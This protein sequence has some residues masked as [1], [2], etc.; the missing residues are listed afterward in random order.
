MPEGL[1]ATRRK[2]IGEQWESDQ[3]QIQEIIYGE[4]SYDSNDGRK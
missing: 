2:V 1:Q 3:D 4:K